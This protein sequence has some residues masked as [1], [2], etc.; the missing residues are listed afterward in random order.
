MGYTM[1]QIQNRY[2][3]V[4][5]AYESMGFKQVP[6]SVFINYSTNIYRA[7]DLSFGEDHRVSA[8]ISMVSKQKD[9]FGFD[10]PVQTLSIM[11]DKYMNGNKIITEDCGQFYCIDSDYF[12]TDLLE[13][14]HA[15]DISAKRYIDY[16]SHISKTTYLDLNKISQRLMDYIKRA[17]DKQI[18][19]D[20]AS[21]SIRDIYFSYSHSL[22]RR[23]VVVIKRFGRSVTESFCFNP[24]LLS[25]YSYGKIV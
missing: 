18:S 20:S 15:R 14:K 23:L 10:Y 21:Y 1:N 25:M 4:V 12:T 5:K 2:N 3:S 13:L 24:K 17:V 7:V 16:H 8:R 6:C 19:D 11:I 9:I 22:G